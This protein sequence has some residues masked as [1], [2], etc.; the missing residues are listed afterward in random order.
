MPTDCSGNP[1]RAYLLMAHLRTSD[2]ILDPVWLDACGLCCP[3]DRKPEGD[4]V[5]DGILWE[6]AA[7]Q[8]LPKRRARRKALTA[9]RGAIE[10]L[11]EVRPLAEWSS[12]AN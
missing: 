3:L 6:A 8:K 12:W 1:A 9:A 4:P 7:A 11:H 10:A 5:M 2:L